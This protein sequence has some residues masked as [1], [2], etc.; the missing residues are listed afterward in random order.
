MAQGSMTP[1]M[2][3]QCCNL[4]RDVTLKCDLRYMSQETLRN[5]TNSAENLHG[6]RKA[7]MQLTAEWQYYFRREFLPFLQNDTSL[8]ADLSLPI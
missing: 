8:S 3:C 2:S 1:I 4:I 5:P 6:F 7:S